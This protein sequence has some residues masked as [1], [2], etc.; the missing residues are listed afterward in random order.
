[1]TSGILVSVKI[2]FRCFFIKFYFSQ[3]RVAPKDFSLKVELWLTV[4]ES[5]FGRVAKR[6]RIV[7]RDFCCTNC[8]TK[9]KPLERSSTDA[10]MAESL[11]NLK[12]P[13]LRPPIWGV[14]LSQFSERCS[15]RFHNVAMYIAT[16]L[17]S[18][19]Y[20]R[21]QPDR[22]VERWLLP[23]ITATDHGDDEWCF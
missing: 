13:E 22:H 14:L 6:N 5:Q 15:E 17:S 11:L 21:P 18:L 23:L 4:C 2:P 3:K 10:A 7:I 12:I 16:R 20:C 19:P 1:M 9:R 8:M